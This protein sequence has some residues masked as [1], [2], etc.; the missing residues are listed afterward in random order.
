M[1]YNISSVEKPPNSTYQFEI[2][3]GISYRQSGVNILMLRIEVDTL[4]VYTTVNTV[5]C[6]MKYK[7]L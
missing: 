2:E 6:Y 1:E 4:Y 3:L 7:Q 5:N